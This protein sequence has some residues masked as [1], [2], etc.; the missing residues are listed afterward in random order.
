MKP[1]VATVADQR[2]GIYVWMLFLLPIFL[3]L[4]GLVT[5]LAAMYSLTGRVQ[6]ALDVAGTSALS[7]SLLEES[8]VDGFATP[9]VDV[10]KAEDTF[11]HLLK[12]N[13]KLNDS[14]APGSASYLSAPLVV[15]DLRIQG[16]APPR[17][18]TT[19]EVT[20]HTTLLHFALGEVRIPVH[21]VSILDMK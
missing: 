8:I 4:L 6:T 13:L 20:F 10:S 21:S 1:A 19:V 3:L 14:L 12:L 16:K 17:I 11:V 18:Q 9:E 5:D 2:G 15:K 7:S